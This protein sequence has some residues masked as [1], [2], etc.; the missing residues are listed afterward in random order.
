MFGVLVLFLMSFVAAEISIDVSLDK[1]TYS[2]GENV[3]YT[4]RLLE[5]EQEISGD[6]DVVFSDALGRD[7]FEKNVMANVENE[8][9]IEGGYFGGHWNVE[10]SYQDA[11]GKGI[12]IVQEN[13]E[14]KFLIEEDNLII[15]NLGNVYYT[16]TVQI[17]IGD[18]IQTISPN[19][20]VGGEK[21]LKLVAPAGVYNIKVS[22]GDVSF[23]QEN[24]EL[25]GT[26][27]VVGAVDQG[28]VG[29]AGLG[30]VGEDPSNIDDRFF[31]LDK[32]PVALVFV[33]AVFGLGI[34]LLIERRYAK[35]K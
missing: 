28:L 3:K 11:E 30:G 19:I 12:F 17:T 14:V 31:S 5:D 10:A 25:F 23:S 21:E 1:E 24:V 15:R 7:V 8:F 26:G 4:I 33:G 34:L 29:Y 27:N 9:P 18:K 13:S 6:V 22:D 20:P 35:K 16:K 32:L 2:V